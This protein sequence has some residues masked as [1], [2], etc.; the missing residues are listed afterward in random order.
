[1]A[2]IKKQQSENETDID[3]ICAKAG[4]QPSYTARAAS[5]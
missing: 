3:S 1:M 5:L 4:V 2:F